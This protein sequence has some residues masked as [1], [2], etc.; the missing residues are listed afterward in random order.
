MNSRKAQ[1][2]IASQAAHQPAIVVPANL[3][4]LA[5]D[6][7]SRALSGRLIAGPDLVDALTEA[8]RP[9]LADVVDIRDR[10]TALERALAPQGPAR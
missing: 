8:L 3:E 2:G 6:V 7:F 9:L 1:R 10:L 5:T 4:Q